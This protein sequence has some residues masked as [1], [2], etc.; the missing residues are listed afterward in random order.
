MLW[1][2]LVLVAVAGYLACGGALGR[3]RPA[4]RP[5]RQ[6]EAGRPPRLAW[7]GDRGRGGSAVASIGA[8]EPGRELLRAAGRVWP[9]FA[10]L[11]DGQQ[12]VA[13][14]ALAEAAGFGLAVALGD[15]APRA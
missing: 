13:P 1:L 12:F 8:S 7:A 15:A 5:G 6:P 14:L 3:G 2:A 9:G 11:R 4:A 10:V